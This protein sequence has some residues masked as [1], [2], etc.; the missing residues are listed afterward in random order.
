VHDYYSYSY[1]AAYTTH[2]LL[3]ICL[4]LWPIVPKL[5]C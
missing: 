5:A 4:P 3:H 1:I 2:T